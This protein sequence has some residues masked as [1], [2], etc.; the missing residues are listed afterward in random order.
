MNKKQREQNYLP[1]ALNS[2]SA[3]F[4]MTAKNLISRD[5][6]PGK[7]L[8]KIKMKKIEIKKEKKEKKN[9]KK[10]KRKKIK[11]IEINK[12]KKKNKNKKKQKRINYLPAALNSISASFKMTAKN[13]IPCGTYPGKSLNKRGEKQ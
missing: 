4:K 10:K 1:A 2:I 9:K 3:S 7:S 5:T 12:G 13:L 8:N 11:K 6:C